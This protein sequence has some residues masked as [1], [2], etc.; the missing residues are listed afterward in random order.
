MNSDEI[1]TNVLERI[2]RGEVHMRPKA[3]FVA[4]AALLIVSALLALATTVFIVSF[5]LFSVRQSGVI[6]LLGFGGQGLLTF[7]TII[8]WWLLLLA[9]ACLIVLE[10]LVRRFRFGYRVPVLEVMLVSF[11]AVL[12]VAAGVSL[13]PVHSSLLNAADRDTLP[14]VGLL[15]EQVHDSHKAQGIYRGVVTALGTS[16]ITLSH[17]DTDRDTDDGTWVVSPPAEF[18]L[19]T[20]RVGERLYVAGVLNGGIVDAYGIEPY[21]ADGR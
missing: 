20:L 17:D 10:L 7:L 1:K 14:L 16:T 3:Y 15:Y 21:P 19:S 18:D 6:F 9:F 12:L 11:V 13:S 8:P 2:R 5:V 4:R